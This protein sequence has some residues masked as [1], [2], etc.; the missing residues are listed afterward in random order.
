MSKC[1]TG[2]EWESYLNKIARPL[3]CRAVYKWWTI[4]LYKK[5]PDTGIEYHVDGLD[6]IR[7][8]EDYLKQLKKGTESE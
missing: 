5:D 4:H 7:D 2:Y 8:V 1:K 6:S 3:G